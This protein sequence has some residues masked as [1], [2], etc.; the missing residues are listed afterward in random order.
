MPDPDEIDWDAPEEEESGFDDEP[1]QSALNTSATNRALALRLN[2]FM[3]SQ[4][5]SSTMST[6]QRNG[7]SL[8]DKGSI[9][10]WSE[11]QPSPSHYSQSPP[12]PKT[13][14]GKKDPDT[15]GSRAA[16]RRP[17]SGMHARSHSVPVV[18]DTE[19]K[20]NNVVANKFGTWGVGSK[21]VTEDWNEDFDFELAAPA[22]VTHLQGEEKRVD[23]G[24]EMFVPKSIRDQQE[25]VVANI[26]LL[27]EW[28]LLIEE[29]KELRIRA[30]ALDMMNGS[31]AA[32]WQEVDAMIELADQET[33]EKTLDPQRSRPSSPAF[34]DD[35]FDE[36][37]FAIANTSKIR[38]SSV[39]KDSKTSTIPEDEVA[40][41]GDAR[42][43]PVPGLASPRPRRDS[44]AVA[45]SVIA[46]LQTKRTGTSLRDSTSKKVPFD[47]ATL[48]HIVPYVNGLKR[49]VKDALRETEGLYS[50][51]RRQTQGHGRHANG[52]LEEEPAFQ[53][54]FK[55]PQ[56]SSPSAQRHARRNLAVTDNDSPDRAPMDAPNAAEDLATTLRAMSLSASP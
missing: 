55:G 15:R 56:P 25:N 24:H 4:H 5:S 19:G 52:D 9:F 53:A 46:A 16:G 11:E 20:K 8:A 39:V 47:T 21:G 42:Q 33:E 10:D 50:S 27:R 49:K 36:P 13:V 32:A 22:V 40:D 7:A 38:R 14:H 26:G 28:G 48:R 44:E 43:P 1:R 45:R 29:L 54:I 6:P 51:P 3:R 35:I 30:V 37:E 17:P 23:S 18:P 2:P 31:H 41:A 12:R 34:D